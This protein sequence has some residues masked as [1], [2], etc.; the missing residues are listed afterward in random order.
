MI[1]VEAE[2]VI[3][4]IN[5]TSEEHLI[6]AL[7]S[8][9]ADESIE[10]IKFNRAVTHLDS[11][12]VQERVIIRRKKKQ[13]QQLENQADWSDEEPQ[14]RPPPTGFGIQKR[15]KKASLQY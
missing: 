10:K 15:L 14:A 12:S 5:T 2:S 3:S 6:S 4:P 8:C 13:L 1:S 7:T 9:Q 11:L